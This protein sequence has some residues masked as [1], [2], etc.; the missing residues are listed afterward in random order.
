[1]SSSEIEIL[2]VSHKYPPKI[3]GMEKQSFELINSS[4]LY[5]KVH[6]L[7]YDNNESILTFFFHLNRRIISKIKAN[8]SI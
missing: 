8:P 1:M 7:V 2:F 4:A 3:G 5:L 6:T